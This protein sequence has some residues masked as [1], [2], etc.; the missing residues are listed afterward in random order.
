[1]QITIELD[2]NKYYS[3][4]ELANLTRSSLISEK[5]IAKF[6]AEVEAEAKEAEAKEKENEPDGITNEINN[7][8]EKY[9]KGKK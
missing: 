8:I 5:V 9:G 3:D 4:Q 7:R 6:K 2:E 1:M